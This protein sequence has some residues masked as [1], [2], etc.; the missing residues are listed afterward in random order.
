MLAL[1]LPMWITFPKSTS[2]LLPGNHLIRLQCRL[3]AWRSS[4][5]QRPLLCLQP[6]LHNISG[7]SKQNSQSTCCE[8]CSNP[9]SNIQ[10]V[11]AVTCKPDKQ[12][13]WRMPTS[14]SFFLSLFFN[15]FMLLKVLNKYD[16]AIYI[17]CHRFTMKSS[18]K[19]SLQLTVAQSEVLYISSSLLI[20]SYSY[21]FGDISN[22]NLRAIVPT[23]AALL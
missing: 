16:P 9:C 11:S 21:K 20:P 1:L 4:W 8:T 14:T 23:Y 19:F 22:A 15:L 13:L 17:W 2:T 12:L 18:L 7:L 6:H 5:S 3:V 10:T